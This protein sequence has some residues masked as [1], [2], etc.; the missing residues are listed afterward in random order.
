MKIRELYFFPVGVESRG[1]FGTRNNPHP[2]G[3]FGFY[4]CEW[5]RRSIF[6]Q[7][8]G[9]QSVIDYFNKIILFKL[10]HF[11]NVFLFAFYF[12]YRK[13]QPFFKKILLAMFLEFYSLNAFSSK[14][15]FSKEI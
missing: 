15:Y 14:F 12:Y 4:P 1:Y 7:N 8:S 2:L 10:F 5:S 9:S 6:S 13:N 11:R 3:D